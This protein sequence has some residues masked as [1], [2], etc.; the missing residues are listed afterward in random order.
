MTFVVE[1]VI[2]LIGPPAGRATNGNWPFRCPFHKGGHEQSPSFFLQED[3]GLAFCHRCHEGWSAISLLRRLGARQSL[4]DTVS[5]QIGRYRK[6]KPHVARS[7]LLP[8]LPESLLGVFDYCPLSLLDAGFDKEVLQR[9]E[10]G[11]DQDNDR[12]T[13]PLR[14][15]LGR[16][17]GVSGKTEVKYKVYLK[18][19][20]QLI[21]GYKAPETFPKGRLVWNL[22]TVYPTYFHG[23]ETAPLVVVEGFKACMWVFQNGYKNVVA[24]LGSWLSEAQCA[25]LQRLGPEHY[26]L[27]LDNDE[28]GWSGMDRAAK[29]LSDAR[30]VDWTTDEV[31]LQPDDLTRDRIVELIEGARTWYGR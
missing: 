27:F 22:H 4:I 19:L 14:D 6:P 21:V 8:A 25:L 13:Y 30:C 15:H 12:I 17:V 26:V 23:D 5:E 31:G 9:F 3:T 18:E 2:G 16:L 11:V 28:A 7:D 24:L 10:V 20:E 1:A 29:M